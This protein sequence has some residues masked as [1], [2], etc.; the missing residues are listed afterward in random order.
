MGERCKLVAGEKYEAIY[1]HFQYMD[2]W[3]LKFRFALSSDQFFY[4][5]ANPEARLLEQVRH[6]A[7]PKSVRDFQDIVVLGKFPLFPEPIARLDIA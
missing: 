5:V 7:V 1:R 6:I 3:Q 4:T 2:L